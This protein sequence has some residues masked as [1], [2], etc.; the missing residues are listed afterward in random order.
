MNVFNVPKNVPK[1]YRLKINDKLYNKLYTVKKQLNQSANG[2]TYLLEHN[3]ESKP[4]IA[5]YIKLNKK[6][7][8][9][10]QS[11]IKK[12]IEKLRQNS[13]LKS[14]SKIYE[15]PQIEKDKILIIMEF[16]EGVS[17][18][19]KIQLNIVDKKLV[20]NI[21][22]AKTLYHLIKNICKNLSEIHENGI[23]HGNLNPYN[24]FIQSDGSIK[25]Y[26]FNIC[27]L[28]GSEADI[29]YYNL[30]S[31][32][33]LWYAPEH[34]EKIKDF[35]ETSD[36]WST[37]I[38]IYQ[39]M[40]R[41]HPFQLENA[42]IDDT[43]NEI[44]SVSDTLKTLEYLPKALNN[45]IKICLT[46]NISRRCKSIKYLNE[47]ITEAS[48][49]KICPN[50]HKNEYYATQCSNP[51]CKIKF[52]SEL[53]I[54]WSPINEWI[55]Y[56]DILESIPPSRSR[57][58]T[59]KIAPQNLPYQQSLL[60]QGYL[61]Y[62][63]FPGSKDKIKLELLPKPKFDI[64]P[65]IIELEW[66]NIDKEK[67]VEYEL[68][69]IKS[70]AI[71]T[72]IKV[73][74]NGSQDL[75]TQGVRADDIL[76]QIIIPE[77]C[78][79][80]FNFK[81]NM[82]KINPGDEFNISFLINMQNRNNPISLNASDLAHDLKIK[83]IYPP[84]LNFISKLPIS[85]DV[86][87]NA[88]SVNKEIEIE[89]SGGGEIRI[90][91][92]KPKTKALIKNDISDIISFDIIRNPIVLEQK[93]KWRIRYKI[94][95]DQIDLPQ[96]ELIIIFNFQEK[97]SG[98]WENKEKQIQLIIYLENYREAEL[99]AVD[100]GTTN[101]F[102]VAFTEGWD[103]QEYEI[104][105]GDDA[106]RKTKAIPSVIH[107][108]P[109]NKP[110]QY[111][112]GM[113]SLINFLQGENNSFRSFK[114][115]IGEYN[116]KYTIISPDSKI[117]KVD[118]DYLIIDYLKLFKD[119]VE[120][121]IG[122]KFNNFIFT[123]PGKFSLTKL[124]IFKNILKKAG[125]ES[126][127]FLDE[128]TAGALYFIKEKQGE[129]L[130][131]VFDFGGGTV[132]ITY[133][134]VN[135]MDSA[136]IKIIDIDGLNNFGG[137]DV[138][139][140]ILNMITEK[141]EKQ[142]KQIILPGK[143]HA[144]SYMEQAY[145]NARRLWSFIEKDIKIDVFN[146]G[147]FYRSL[148]KL[149]YYN[150][151]T[152]RLDE[153]KI[154]RFEVLKSEVDNLIYEKISESVNLVL[155]IFERNDNVNKK[156]NLKRY[157]LV[158]G[159]SSQIPLVKETFEAYKNGKR[160]QWNNNG[161]SFIAKPEYSKLE[162]DEYFTFKDRDLTK[163][164]SCVASGAAIY[165]KNIIKHGNIKVHNLKDKNWSRFGFK[166]PF[167]ARSKFI[168]L[169]PKNRKLIPEK[170]IYS[171]NEIDQNIYAIAVQSKKIIFKENGKILDTI[172]I[173]EHFGYDDSITESN[174]QC[175][176]RYIIDKPDQ[177]EYNEIDAV[178]RLYITDQFEIKLDINIKGNWI[179]ASKYKS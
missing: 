100:F 177:Y 27:Y 86:L 142:G 21:V 63:Q 71:I 79:L 161:V 118:A 3:L 96:L 20:N 28:N 105:L 156:N 60:D 146:K 65:G 74:I 168:E 55:H 53:K 11:I 47:Q 134:Y 81:I 157:I 167:L 83:V 121:K 42:S 176:G 110:N 70:K 135:H 163:L 132:D 108:Y 101:S 107:Y 54:I 117:K 69:I 41:K 140:A 44:T 7:F 153:E 78:P 57:E 91:G 179:N 48:F 51:E 12:N 88:K 159:Q 112:I 17:L 25:F 76:N 58:M 122:Y 2:E 24:I 169:I 94:F 77:K 144:D 59:F 174:C 36:I 131:L 14:I 16:F 111:T 172:D 92:V 109:K 5:K 171:L 45:I 61:K 175:V 114:R 80:P 165:C 133:L 141:L 39:M 102:C 178:I 6:T 1:K 19:E 136:E 18:A 26:D 9:S 106:D 126:T 98:T 13:F 34:I 29:D 50:N 89:N 15:D 137:D 150:D 129:Y 151:A 67:N 95:P 33:N 72:E 66:N 123:H 143:K 32:S 155:K 90:L 40:T 49:Y 130:L 22:D 52:T 115:N 87:K 127:F 37:G 56:S 128:A 38:M 162:Y 154:D 152:K 103:S 64:N 113:E 8:S 62:I 138:T 158:S 46:K 23:I 139:N 31:Y 43:I 166:L 84:K 149:F 35:S 99:L 104:D 97:T 145:S 160:P 116:E 10:K 147:K 68:S 119:K 120:E 164:K 173:Y 82:S 170:M 75:I 125:F 4:Y 73:F 93:N 124:K 85:V 30:L 148:T